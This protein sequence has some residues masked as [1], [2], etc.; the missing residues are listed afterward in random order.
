MSSIFKHV[1]KGLQGAL[2]EIQGENLSTYYQSLLD[3]PRLAF[4]KQL[5][6]FLAMLPSLERQRYRQFEPII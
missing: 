5:V 3:E 1:T 6:L 4:V 2:G